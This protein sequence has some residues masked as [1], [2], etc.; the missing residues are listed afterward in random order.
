MYSVHSN[1]PISLHRCHNWSFGPCSI[2]LSWLWPRRCD[3]GAFNMIADFTAGHIK[4]TDQQTFNKHV[5]SSKAWHPYPESASKYGSNGK[6]YLFK[7]PLWSCTVNSTLL[8]PSQS[9]PEDI[10]HCWPACPAMALVPQEYIDFQQC[11]RKLS[12]LCTEDILSLDRCVMGPLGF[13]HARYLYSPSAREMRRRVS[14]TR[15]AL[16]SHRQTQRMNLQRCA[17]NNSGRQ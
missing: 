15:C 10:L 17:A 2:L 14:C 8:Q 5:S 6:W 9:P 1:R 16:P 7:Q 3:A 13:Q 11:Y 4:F 12:S